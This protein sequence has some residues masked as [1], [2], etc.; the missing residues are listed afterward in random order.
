MATDH[1]T[2]SPTGPVAS[3]I[4]TQSHLALAHC[5]AESFLRH[6][7]DGCVHVLH[8]DG[9]SSARADEHPD[10]RILT[11]E[12]SSLRLLE[13]LSVLRARYSVFELCNGLKPFLLEHLLD[14]GHERVLYLDSDLYITA[15]LDPV[16]QPLEQHA[17]VLTPHLCTVSGPGDEQMWR[18]HAVIQ[19][20]VLNG[21]L[22]GV[23]DR[24]DA[25]RFL[26]WWGERV[27]LAGHKRIAEGFNCDQKWLDLAVGFDVDLHI[28]RD[29]GLNTAYWNLDERRLALEGTTHLV[30]GVP[31]RFFHFSGFDPETP[32]VLTRS[33]TWHTLTTRPDLVPVAEEYRAALRCSIERSRPG[34][35]DAD[36]GFVSAA[37]PAVVRVAV[38][39]PG[40]D[41]I[42]VS[43]VIPARDP[44]PMLRDAVASAL[45]QTGIALEVIVVDDGSSET[46][47]KHL[48]PDDRVRLLIGAGAGV[49]AARNK[50]LAQARGRMVVFLDADDEMATTDR[51]ASQ[52]ALFD[53]DPEL[54]IVHSGWSVTDEEGGVVVER[55]P[56]DSLPALDLRTW[57]LSPVV[58]PSAMAF[59]RTSVLAVGGFDER[60]TQVEDVDLVWRLARDHGSAW[61]RCVTTTRRRHGANA[62]SDIGAQ[63][64]CLATVL[65][66]LFADP[67]LPD[68]VRAVQRTARM[69]IHIWL[70]SR[71]HHQGDA[72]SMAEH[73]ALSAVWSDEPPALLSLVWAEHFARTAE[74][75]GDRGFD[76]SQ[77]MNLPQWQTLVRLGPH[78]ILERGA[79]HATATLPR[80]R[81]A[82]PVIADE[83]RAAPGG[84][85][86]GSQRVLSP[87]LD[88]TATRQRTFGTH[89]SGWSNAM[90]ALEALHVD[91]G[92]ALDPFVE[93]TYH[94]ANPGPAL[95]SPWVG[96]LHGP[97]GQPAWYPIDHSP[98]QLL[99][100]IRFRRD[101]GHCAGLFTLSEELRSWWSQR[102]DVEIQTV[103]HPT[104]IPATQFSMSAFMTNPVPR[105]VQIGSWLRK[106]HAIYDLPVRTLRRTLVHQHAPYIDQ[107]FAA[108]RRAFHLS[109]AVLGSDVETLPF[110]T[111]AAYDDLL[112][113]NI[114]FIE[115]YAAAANNV[116]LECL[117]RAT[118]LLVNPLPAVR[119]HL[120]DDYPLYFSSR[121]EAAR[122]AEDLPLI[123][124]AHHYLLARDRNWLQL[125]AFVESVADG[126]VRHQIIRSCGA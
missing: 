44:G 113:S 77:L 41:A 49:S 112:A 9:P 87:W 63:A 22:V 62:S 30:N 83:R 27:T 58:L 67:T 72:D 115:L 24:A 70:A 43:V 14:A 52:L 85:N 124:A 105:V 69:W 74:E 121:R 51:L 45:A 16:L 66:R 97:P 50:G 48:P 90:G 104:E 71:F 17:L 37:G 34:Q 119:E 92:I 91:G 68:D 110:L 21:G 2:L 11:V 20:G 79:R 102:V 80:P 118:P 126:A 106:L 39:P 101:L 98:E 18:D 107:L 12:L 35:V 84:V 59:R 54:G 64:R 1:T 57:V 82:R 75:V 7:P 61:H 36:E 65:D 53:A 33:L 32:E 13:P 89:R 42:D 100:N 47:T 5:M 38:E 125:S 94:D 60:L 56:W 73:L 15:P 26:R 81:P 111:D 46:L 29:P 114:V 99:C 78:A 103:R 117:A 8:V 88:L 40:P 25:R 76:Q 108:E 122:K 95:R 10:P 116:V 123:E 31:L 86:A 96:F 4:A 6:H 28:A 55:T 3:T 23:R 19:Y 93:H 109:D 120:G